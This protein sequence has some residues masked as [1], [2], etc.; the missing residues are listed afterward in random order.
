[1]KKAIIIGATS[2]I[3]RELAVLLAKN[4]YYV[5]ITGRRKNLLE[6][7]QAQMPNNFIVSD[8]DITDT[9]IV[10]NKL[11]ELKDK[12]GGIDLIVLSSGA[13][14]RNRNGLDPQAEK[15][16]IDVNVLGFKEVADWSIKYFLNQ[17]YGHFVALTSISGMRGIG[18]SPSY[19][20]TKAFQ[21]N[22]LESL[23]QLVENSKMPVFVTE[24]RPGFVDTQMARSRKKFWVAPVERA[25]KQI[26]NAIKKK[27]KKVYVTN[28]WRFVGLI[29]KLIPRRIYIKLN[30]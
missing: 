23:Q 2:G 12:L 27:K 10:G 8:F 4:N 13:S 24:I 26:F 1:M 28:R 20:A 6:E 21:I 15:E 11:N 5:G 22:Y 29:L 25:V 16:I 9:K 17:K 18:S 19:S 7:L 30:F 14:R 3:G